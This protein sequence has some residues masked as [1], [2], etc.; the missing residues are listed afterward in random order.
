M[1]T[2]N[3]PADSRIPFVDIDDLLNSQPAHG[4]ARTARGAVAASDEASSANA[5]AHDLEHAAQTQAQQDAPAA[6]SRFRIHSLD[7]V[8]YL[9]IALAALG[10]VAS[11]YALISQNNAYFDR[12]FQQLQRESEALNA[13]LA[14]NEAILA[15]ASSQT[16]VPVPLQPSASSKQQSQQPAEDASQAVVDAVVAEAVSDIEEVQVS[17]AKTTL[18]VTTGEAAVVTGDSSDEMRA[19]EIDAL[20]NELQNLQAA[21]RSQEVLI[22]ELMA[23]NSTISQGATERAAQVV[24]KAV[25]RAVAKRE[26]AKSAVTKSE[27][28]KPR[29]V[30][31]T[32][33]LTKPVQQDSVEPVVTMA[34]ESNVP[35]PS[36]DSSDT[37][38][39]V[40]RAYNQY[41]LGNYDQ[42]LELYQRVVQFDP[43][44]RDANLGIA[45]S[46][47]LLEDYALAETHYRHLLSLYPVDAAA[48][49]GLLNLPST[50]GGITELELQQHAQQQT[51]S[52]DLFAILG[53]YFA[54][55]IRWAD[56]ESAFSA[57][58]RDEGN[59]ADYLYNY[60]VVLD[61]LARQR[62]AI[63]YYARALK[64]AES[65]MF[66]FDSHTAKQRLDS[67]T[68]GS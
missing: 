52:A 18:P 68:T 23:Q 20:K 30:E 60:A 46:A 31:V 39:I 26:V 3:K 54:R 10:L 36:V 56:A 62:D 44:H 53:N 67:L 65:G 57:A 41:Q 12:E 48:F 49:S 45:A 55:N 22:R 13:R 64:A 43:Y 40:V 19:K 2:G 37:D 58:L 51:G 1:S 8:F 15:S 24:P 66:S 21:V 16:V 35:A 59:N 50:K 63:D 9:I 61:N 32:W 33:P 47:R 11:L 7:P 27:E 5:P 14:A 4:A 25:P 34:V 17:D 6:R 28:Q 29:E 38:D 42:A